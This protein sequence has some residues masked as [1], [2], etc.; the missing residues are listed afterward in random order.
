MANE[1]K[2]QQDAVYWVIPDG[3]TGMSQFPLLM[4][5]NQALRVAKPG[6]KVLRIPPCREGA[7]SR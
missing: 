5:L 4:S 1:H 2:A 6:D 7:K 3:W